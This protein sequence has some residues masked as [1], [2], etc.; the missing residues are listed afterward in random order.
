MDSVPI[1]IRTKIKNKLENSILN[2]ISGACLNKYFVSYRLPA[3][4]SCA[5]S[6]GPGDLLC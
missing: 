5:T 6:H 1:P 2:L 3:P 4:E